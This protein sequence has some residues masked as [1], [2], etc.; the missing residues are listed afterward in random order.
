MIRFIS[1]QKIFLFYAILFRAIGSGTRHFRFGR[2]PSL[3][4]PPS[5][6]LLLC[7]YFSFAKSK[8]FVLLSF[9][10]L[11]LTFFHSPWAKWNIKECHFK[12]YIRDLNKKHNFIWLKPHLII[13]CSATIWRLFLSLVQTRKRLI[14]SNGHMQESDVRQKP[15]VDCVMRP[16]FFCVL[17]DKAKESTHLMIYVDTE[18]KIDGVFSS[19][20]NRN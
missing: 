1:P 10:I 7:R 3:L 4:M 5:V 12:Q 11:H 6:L 17:R 19:C 13:S 8:I 15:F 18:T 2:V 9:S 20:P 16:I 14:D